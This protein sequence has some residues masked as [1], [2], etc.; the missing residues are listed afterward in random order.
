MSPSTPVDLC[1]SPR[2]RGWSSLPT[3]PHR[4]PDPGRDIG[5]GAA[6]GRLSPVSLNWVVSGSSAADIGLIALE[7]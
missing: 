6:L 7:V 1:V 4:L 3:R 2:S 5:G